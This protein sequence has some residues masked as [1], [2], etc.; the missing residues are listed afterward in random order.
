[1]KILIDTNI[2][3]DLALIRMP[4]Y[5]EADEIFYLMEQNKFKGYISA[6]TLTDIYYILRKQKGK[7]WSKEFLNRLTNLCQI[8]P[9]T[10]QVV[11]AALNNSYKDF[12]DDIQYHSAIINNLDGIVTRN[13]KDFPSFSLTIFTPSQLIA[14]IN[15][16]QTES[17][18]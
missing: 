15:D 2:I 16:K 6:T 18:I 1:M 11:I 7:N 8:N 4:F 10:E 13:I 5:K 12:E 9:I 14:I 17:K 3:L